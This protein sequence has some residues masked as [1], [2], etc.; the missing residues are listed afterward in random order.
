MH[1]QICLPSQARCFQFSHG[2]LLGPFHILPFSDTL[3][4]W[5]RNIILRVSS[6]LGAFHVRQP[7]KKAACA[8]DSDLGNPFFLFLEVDLQMGWVFG[9]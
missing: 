3:L 1:G 7:F 2:S 9:L 5:D 6:R 8:L 4:G